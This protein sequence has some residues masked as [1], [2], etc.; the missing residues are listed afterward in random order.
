MDISQSIQSINQEWS[1]FLF[2][3]ENNYGY[4]HD[5]SLDR[6]KLFFRCVIG[7]EPN[8]TEKQMLNKMIGD[9][10]KE[11]KVFYVPLN[12]I[13]NFILE[14]FEVNED[15]K[16]FENFLD[17]QII[18]YLIMLDKNLQFYFKNKKNI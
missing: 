11:K 3:L 6:A 4:Q 15:N 1:E 5:Y 9:Y 8:E 16:G 14:K 2:E 10:L 17:I 12:E 18:N 13:K 7:R